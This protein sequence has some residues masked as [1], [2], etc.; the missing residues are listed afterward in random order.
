MRSRGLHAAPA[1]LLTFCL[2]TLGA[3]SAAAAQ[4]FRADEWVTECDSS[5]GAHASDC[6]ITVPFWQRS[7]APRGSFALVVMLQTGNIGIVGEPFPIRA[8]L[9]VDK[10]PPIEC[11]QTRYCVFPS[12]QALTVLEQL[13][14]GSLILIDVYTDKGEFSFSLTPKGFQAGM[15]QIRAWGYRTE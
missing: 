13:K 3:L 2:Q 15:A 1:L 4:Q 8:V 10:N 7:G 5:P 12:T 11:R 6:S 14:I 9:R